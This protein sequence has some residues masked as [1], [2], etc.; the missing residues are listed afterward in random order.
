MPYV[1][2]AQYREILSRLGI[3]KERRQKRK[4]GYA[5]QSRTMKAKRR[6]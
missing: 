6:K 3:C 1:K 4:A 5:K 2:V